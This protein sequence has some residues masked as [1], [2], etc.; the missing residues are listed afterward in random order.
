MQEARAERSVVL[1]SAH[2]RV[3]EGKLAGGRQIR[4]MQ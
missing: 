1:R 2:G 3:S 4:L